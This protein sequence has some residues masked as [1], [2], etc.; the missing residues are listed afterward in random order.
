MLRV[1]PHYYV[2]LMISRWRQH[3][4]GSTIRLSQLKRR[5][6][7][8]RCRHMSQSFQVSVDRSLLNAFPNENQ[9]IQLSISVGNHKISDISLNQDDIEYIVTHSASFSVDGVKS[10]NGMTTISLKLSS[11]WCEQDVLKSM[12]APWRD[13]SLPTKQRDSAQHIVLSGA[14]GENW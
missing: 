7:R 1:I 9:H 13:Y 4:N 11:G 8:Q 2:R 5:S 3:E 6:S 14:S 10:E 12:H